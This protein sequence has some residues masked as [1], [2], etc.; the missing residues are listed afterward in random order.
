M[1]KIFSQIKRGA[2]FVASKTKKL[3]IS[4]QLKL[5]IKLN[6][7]DLTECFERLGRLYYYQEKNEIDNSKK[8]EMTIAKCEEITEKI[9]ELKLALAELENKTLCEHCG[10]VIKM[11]APYCSKCGQKIVATKKVEVT[12]PVEGEVLD[13]LD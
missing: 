2:G 13:M 9:E 5:D 12:T 4:A 7:A 8:I 3:A 1:K 10:S 6:E 11:D